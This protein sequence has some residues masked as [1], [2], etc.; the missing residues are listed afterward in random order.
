MAMQCGPPNKP[1]ESAANAGANKSDKSV[2]DNFF[3]ENSA[4][5]ISRLRHFLI[6]LA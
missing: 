3:W 4:S 1:I 6:R 2:I 5:I